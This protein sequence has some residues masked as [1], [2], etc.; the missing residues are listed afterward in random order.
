MPLEE[1]VT[2]EQVE[3]FVMQRLSLRQLR[4]LLAL[5]KAGSLS[6]AADALHVTQPA[7]SKSLGEVERAL[8]KTLFLRRGRSIRATPLGAQMVRLAQRMEQLLRRGSEEAAALMRGASG[9][10]L[11]GATNAALNPLLFDTIARMKEELPQ[12]SL[13]VR[14]HALSGMFEDLR[15]G[16]LDLVV[17]RQVGDAPPELRAHSVMPVQERVVI[18]S[19]HPLARERR[20]SW[21][22]L[23]QQAWIWPLPGTR[24][25]VRRDRFWHQLGLPLP[26]NVLQ[27]D[28]LMLT[29][30]LL[31]RMPLVAIMPSPIARSAALSG[32]VRL[33]PLD[34]DLGLG[35]L[36]AWQA[37]EM[38]NPFVDRFIELLRQQGALAAEQGPLSQA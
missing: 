9:E 10:L 31:Q 38:S 23:N 18:S 8:G 17:A 35:G 1:E 21:E 6:A 28:D 3:A 5:S 29:L 20:L 16:R 27:T 19:V 4:M 22:T 26:S 2:P 34:L 24:S 15:Q 12:L 30:G 36:C 11:I 37:E 13:A 32:A 14:T 7:I 25:R 33:L